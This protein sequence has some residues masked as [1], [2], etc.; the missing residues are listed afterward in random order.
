[1]RST[2]RLKNR[3]GFEIERV[4]IAESFGER[5]IGLMFKEGLAINE[6]MLIKKCNSIHTFFMNFPIHAIFLNKKLEIIKI[7]KNINPWRM[8]GM[9]LGASQ[10]LE[11]HADKDISL[12][13]IGDELE[14][15]CTN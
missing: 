11:V 14:V 9:S 1:M 3:K 13:N 4:S 8:T 7:V 15:L 2:I 10:V 5:L 12:L 6:G